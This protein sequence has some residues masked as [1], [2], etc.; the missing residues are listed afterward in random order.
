MG[1][2]S[3]TCAKTQLPVLAAPAWHRDAPDL[4]SVVVIKQDGSVIR[5]VYDGYGRVGDTPVADLMQNGAKMV[6]AKYYQGEPY[7]G[8]GCSGRAPGQGFSYRKEIL[9]GWVAQGGFPSFEAFRAAYAA[10][11]DSQYGNVGDLWEIVVDREGLSP[12]TFQARV[13]DDIVM[14]GSSME[15]GLVF[16]DSDAVEAE[17]GDVR[18]EAIF[19]WLNEAFCALEKTE[20][21]GYAQR[22][23]QDEDDE[24]KWSFTARRIESNESSRPAAPRG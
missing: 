14:C 22:F 3:W 18:R 9:D 24:P 5:G 7:S 19:L 21:G 17:I 23:G 6:I 12:F 2:F 13:E 15:P 16:V 11:E 10:V 4:C 20:D 1:F 8:L